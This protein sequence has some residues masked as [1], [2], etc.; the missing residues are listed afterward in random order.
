VG[1]CFGGAQSFLA[2]TNPSLAID[3]AIGFYGTLDPSRIGFEFEMPAP[4]AQVAKTRR[5]VL[6]L[7]GGGDPLIPPEDIDAFDRGL[8]DAGV[9]HELVSYPGAPHSFFDR[10]AAEYAGASEDAW[11]RVLEFLD[12]IGAA[13]ANA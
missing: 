7:F 8:A 4:L 9:E 3:A 13:T 2:A 1:F 10:S 5:P 11:R 6:G 12:R